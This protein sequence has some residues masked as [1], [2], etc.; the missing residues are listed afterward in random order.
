MMTRPDDFRGENVEPDPIPEAAHNS[1]SG[2]AVVF[3]FFLVL[4]ACVAIGFWASLR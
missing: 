2:C 4:L 3:V 1:G